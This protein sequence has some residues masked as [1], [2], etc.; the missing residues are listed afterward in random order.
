MKL[1]VTLILFVREST[2][3][4][5]V[6]RRGYSL[7]IF[8]VV[9]CSSHMALLKRRPNVSQLCSVVVNCIARNFDRLE[10]KFCDR[11]LFLFSMFSLVC[12]LMVKCLIFM[13]EALMKSRI[14]HPWKIFLLYGV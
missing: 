8:S 10:T 12:M 11:H 13:N 1:P 9:L 3:P 7:K 5:M 6:L 2:F 14:C 4:F